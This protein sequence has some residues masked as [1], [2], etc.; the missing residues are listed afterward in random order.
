[1]KLA[2][3]IVVV[4]AVYLLRI[5][6]FA[7]LLLDDAWY[8][9]LG[10]ALSLGEG[11]RLISSSAAAIVPSVPPGFPALLSIVFWFNPSYP[12]NVVALK[13]VSLVAMAGVGV[14]C[15][16]DL[17]RHRDVPDE[18]AL[19]IAAA[20]MLTPA[21]V[22]LATSAVM[23]ECVFTLA[24]LA[25]VI[26]VERATRATSHLSR[27]AL[28]AGACAAATVLIRTAGLAAI[29]ASI[30]YLLVHRR[31]RQAALF[32]ATVVVL[33][34]P[35]QAYSSVNAASADERI[36]HGGTIAFSY[37]E[38]IRR[39]SP[40]AVDTAVSARE[41]IWRG[42]AN[43]AGM[44]TKDVGA[45]VIPELFR[46]P[47]ESGLEVMSVGAP[48]R[49]SMGGAIGTRVVSAVLVV[50]MLWGIYRSSAWLSLPVMLIAA[51]LVMF[52]TVSSLT[53][54][55]VVPLAPFLVW[56]LW[57][58]LGGARVARVAVLVVI[59]F[60]LVDHT[61]YLRAAAAGQSPWMAEARD[62]GTVLTWMQTSLP[63]D[64]PVAS[65]N[66][67]LVYLHTGRQ[68]IVAVRP[69]LNWDSWKASGLRYV[70]ALRPTDI[71]S[72][73]RSATVLLRNGRLW[74]VRM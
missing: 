36:A 40:G 12:D 67:G 68:G 45:V 54:R 35:W 28:V 66:P 63:E 8:L 1:M 25:T 33:V 4:V 41:F 44:A 51:S 62:V 59:G 73:H 47:S 21:L 52:S 49:G 13:A 16:W 15:W 6:P 48:G 38:L 3:T 14:A 24:Q 26:A 58:G 74:V 69:E 46:W 60:H 10:K 32:V 7:G 2:V 53:I 11:F 23:A 5:D 72:R 18:E 27:S 65:S 29:A 9:V 17:T 19:L 42:A 71:P 43:L 56:L 39:D 22:F 34:S 64:G 70:A 20:V 57:R 61:Q 37:G 31:W 50:V 30:G 55:Y